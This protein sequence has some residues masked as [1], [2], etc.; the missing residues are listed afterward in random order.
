MWGERGGGKEV[1]QTQILGDNNDLHAS[2]GMYPRVRKRK[3]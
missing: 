1:Y 2:E 3:T